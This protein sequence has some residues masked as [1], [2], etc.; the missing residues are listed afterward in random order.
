MTLQWKMSDALG[1]TNQLPQTN[2]IQ[3]DHFLFIGGNNCRQHH[4]LCRRNH[5]A[6]LAIGTLVKRLADRYAK[7][8]KSFAYQLSDKDR[9]LADPAGENNGIQPAQ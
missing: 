5:P 9:V 1:L 6:A 2:G 8:L 7:Y 3:R 4:G